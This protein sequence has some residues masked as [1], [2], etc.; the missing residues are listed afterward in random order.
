MSCE[1]KARFRHNTIAFWLS[2]E[3][4]AAVEA[5]IKVVGMDKGAYYRSAVLGQKAE[6][7]GGRY[8]SERLAIILE[9]LLERAK[10]GDASADEEIA[11]ILR[12]LLDL[13]KR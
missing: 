7:I 2:D 9:K 4:K 3:E 1:R 10:G 13:M 12:E 6:L 11:A 8:Q 5:R